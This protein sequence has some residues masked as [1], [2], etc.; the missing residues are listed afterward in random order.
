MFRVA[1]LSNVVGFTVFGYKICMFL[2]Y[3]FL[4]SIPAGM[5]RL[6]NDGNRF[7]SPAELCYI[8]AV[9]WVAL[10]HQPPCQNSE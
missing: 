6:A 5:S 9:L 10:R 8:S 1:L 3:I 7:E 4:C 2:I